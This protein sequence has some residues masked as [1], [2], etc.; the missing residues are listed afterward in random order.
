MPNKEATPSD[1]TYVLVARTNGEAGIFCKVCGRVSWHP[2]DVEH[3]YC[4]NCNKFH[5]DMRV[6][7]AIR[8]ARRKPSLIE[9]IQ[10]FFEKRT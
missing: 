7:A 9:R 2:K 6:E 4:G 3:R 8:A 1:D 5:H 10:A